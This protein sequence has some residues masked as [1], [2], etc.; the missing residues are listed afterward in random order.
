MKI[1]ALA[2]AMALALGCV[3]HA[4]TTEE[5]VSSCRA[6]GAAQVSGEHVSLPQDFNSGVCWGAFGMIQKMIYTLDPNTMKP[7][8][9]SCPPT[10]TAGATRTQL[11]QIFLTYAQ[12]RPEK[13]QEDYFDVALT[14]I[15][16][17][18]P[19]SNR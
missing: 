17:A 11:I 12:A 18:F 5:M 13:Y 15:S 6:I 14:A 2:F 19:C 7:F 8:F 9:Y 10:G 4:E 16:K 1:T 3:C